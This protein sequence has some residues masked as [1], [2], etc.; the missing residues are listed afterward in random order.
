METG[1]RVRECVVLRTNANTDPTERK[2]RHR[3]LEQVWPAGTEEG[4]SG[5]VVLSVVGGVEAGE[6]KE[7][8]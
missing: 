6:I 7:V 4:S 5:A 1:V 3:V 8:C 2:S